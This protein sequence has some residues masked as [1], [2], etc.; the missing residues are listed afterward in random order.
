MAK[1]DNTYLHILAR[2]ITTRLKS[3]AG[4]VVIFIDTDYFCEGMTV[5]DHMELSSHVTR[6]AKDSRVIYIVAAQVNPKRMEAVRA[7]FAGAGSKSI[8]TP[9]E[10]QLEALPLLARGGAK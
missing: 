5:A 8:L 6:W 1:E 4:Q 3:A 10:V 7:D 9:D 2:A